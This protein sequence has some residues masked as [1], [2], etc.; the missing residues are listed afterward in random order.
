MLDELVKVW[1]WPEAGDTGVQPRPITD[2]VIQRGR[3]E[4]PERVIAHYIQ[5]HEPY[6]GSD[7][8]AD[9]RM[10]HQVDDSAVSKGALWE[11][12]LD[13]LRYVLDEVELLLQNVEAKQVLITADH[14]EAF[15]EWG[16]TGHQ[17]CFPH[18]CVRKVPLAETSATDTG[19]HQPQKYESTARSQ[20]DRDEL[21]ANLGYI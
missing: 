10:L 20:R 4:D 18:H 3:S 12:Y 14:G 13:N 6:I 17:I 2:T 9:P 19:E 5:P 21:L 11:A 8:H 7:T 1:T 16:S 15:G